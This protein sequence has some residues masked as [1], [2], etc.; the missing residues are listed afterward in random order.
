MLHLFRA[1]VLNLGIMIVEKQNWEKVVSFIL[2]NYLSVRMCCALVHWSSAREEP[3][4]AQYRE[5]EYKS[6]FRE[7]N[8]REWKNGVKKEKSSFPLC[9]CT[10]AEFLWKHWQ[11]KSPSVLVANLSW[12]NLDVLFQ[13]G[14][15][16]REKRL[17]QQYTYSI[18][19]LVDGQGEAPGWLMAYLCIGL[20]S[21]LQ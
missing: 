5:K 19:R 2:E 14:G 6:L 11:N 10:G 4:E 17:R 18:H 13:A 15:S 1:F 3:D 7:R 20:C 8:E 21:K 12:C 16:S 9:L